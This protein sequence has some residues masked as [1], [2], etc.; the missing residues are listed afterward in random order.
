M[1]NQSFSAESFQE[2]FDKEN[3]K[4]QNVEN[5][6]KVDFQKTLTHLKSIQLLTKAIK[7]EPD[8]DNRKVLYVERKKLKKERE[9]LI[10][11]VLEKASHNLPKKVNEINLIN[12]PVIGKQTYILESNIQNFFMSKKVQWNIL[13]TYKVKQ[14][15]RYAIITQL[16]NLLEDKFPKYVLRTDI[17]S[18]YESIPQNTLR[19]KINDDHLLS[20]LSKRF[21]NRIFEE[22]NRLTSQTGNDNP[23]GIPRGIGISPYLS[24]LYMRQ[25]DNQIKGLK[26]VVYYSRYVD[27]IIIVFIPE[28]KELNQ[29]QLNKYD[30]SVKSIIDLSGLETNN[31]KTK[32]YN[33]LNSLNEIHTTTLQR[34]DGIDIPISYVPNPKTIDFLGY[35]IGSQ[36]NK[37]YTASNGKTKTAEKISI[38]ISENKLVKYK[39]KI[40]IAF[41][42]YKNKKM[43]NPKVAYKLLFSRIEFL[44]SNTRLRNNKARVLIGIYY[45]NVFINNMQNLQK[46]DRSLKYYISRAGFSNAEKENFNK[47]SFVLGFY[48]KK[49]IQIPLKKETY[50]NHNSKKLDLVNA[51]NRGVLRYGLKEINS[52]WK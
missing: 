47:F 26:D 23:K 35:K 36:Q 4:G 51:K 16:I 52:I 6:F 14:A 12:G 20:M 37:T 45:S 3:R 21:I 32:S 29:Q 39:N 42:E 33:L 46:I 38:D 9:E 2:I 17:K 13:K 18:F 8:K 50:K 7:N 44:S 5:L 11:E 15:N 27:D 1:L 31:E 49:Y 22:Y 41:E 10:L 28:K 34:N 25:V 30:T 40:K 43:S 19:N 48:S 24:E